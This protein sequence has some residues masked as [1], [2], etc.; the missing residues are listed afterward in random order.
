MSP[1][2]QRLRDL[3]VERGDA[4]ANIDH[5]TAD[6]GFG[7]RHLGLLSRRPGQRCDVGGGIAR[8]GHVEPSRV[9]DGET[10]S[11]P[12]DDAVQPIAGQTRE[13]INDRPPRAGEAV[14]QRRLPDVGTSDDR[15]HSDRRRN[16]LPLLALAPAGGAGRAHFPPPGTGE[17]SMEICAN[18]PPSSFSAKALTS[19]APEVVV[20]QMM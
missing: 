9:D 13:G 4:I 11:S 19:S 6:I 5:E 18:S 20:R 16:R 12:L 10:L 3:L 8:Q 7:D 17:M 15:D 14:E 2:T 1:A